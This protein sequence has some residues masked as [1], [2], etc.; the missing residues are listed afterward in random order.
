MGVLPTPLRARWRCPPSSRQFLTTDAQRDPRW[1]ICARAF[2]VGV[3]G[4]EG[5]SASASTS[6]GTPRAQLPGAVVPARFRAE[7]WLR[8]KRDFRRGLAQRAG[9]QVRHRGQRFAA[10]GAP[11]AAV[12]GEHVHAGPRE[13]CLGGRVELRR[14]LHDRASLDTSMRV[15]ALRCCG[16][17]LV[18]DS[19]LLRIRAF[20]PIM[21]AVDSD[22]AGNSWWSG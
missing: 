1:P 7:E 4:N 5:F 21:P 15:V 13:P 19:R 10:S 12:R 22:A 20:A 9:W 18:G 16:A 14:V 8:R 2:R 3:F 11:A 6:G 17:S